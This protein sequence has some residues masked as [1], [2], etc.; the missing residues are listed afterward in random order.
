MV[1]S[2]SV[3]VPWTGGARKPKDVMEQPPPPLGESATGMHPASTTSAAATRTNPVLIA[4][5]PFMHTGVCATRIQNVA[6]SAQTK[7]TKKP[8]AG[9]SDKTL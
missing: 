1:R 2:P 6:I 8:Q 3:I 9:L 5:P 4:R 7:R